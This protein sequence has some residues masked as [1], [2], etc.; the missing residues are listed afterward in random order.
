MF[1]ISTPPLVPGSRSTRVWIARGIAVAA[2]IVQLALAPVT[3]EGAISPLADGLDIGVAILL[4][5]LLGFHIAFV[6]SFLIKI[7]P[8]ADLAPT[9]TIAVLIAT[10]GSKT[11]TELKPATV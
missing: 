3:M 10:R 8:F 2:D 7:L 6:P 9:W 4:T 5:A 1:D 11:D